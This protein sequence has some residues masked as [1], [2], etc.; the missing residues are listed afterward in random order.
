MIIRHKW[1]SIGTIFALFTGLGAASASQASQDRGPCA[2]V[3]AACQVAGFVQGGVKSGNGLQIDCI[4]PIMQG[5]APE[6]KAG[7]P[8]PQIDP[9]VVAACKVRNP[10]FGQPRI[11]PPEP[12]AQSNDQPPAAPPAHAAAPG[13][14]NIVFILTDDPSLNLV[15]VTIVLSFLHEHPDSVLWPERDAGDRNNGVPGNHSQLKLL[16]NRR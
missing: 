4:E 14:P 11:P 6:H 1:I 10:R 7:K 15:Q 5:K 16:G 3:I 8:L 9:Q 12:P 2:Q 13:G